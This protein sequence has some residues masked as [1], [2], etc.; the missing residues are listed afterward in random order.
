MKNILTSSSVVAFRYS[1]GI[2]LSSDTS[3]N[4][5]SL[6]MNRGVEKHYVLSNNTVMIVRG[7]Y[8]C[9]QELKK[10]CDEEMEYD[11]SMGT[12]EWIRFV[13][14]VMY[15]KRTRV[16]PLNLSVIV[17]GYDE[18]SEKQEK[19]INSV[20][21]FGQGLI[22]GVIDNVG[23]FYTDDVLA[24]GIASHMALPYIRGHGSTSLDREGA[25]KLMK[26]TMQTLYYRDCMADNH[27]KIVGVE[28]DG[29]WEN[30]EMV[31][32]GN[33]EDGKYF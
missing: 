20:E 11:Q 25:I 5:G 8:S 4:Y 2:I 3:L 29:I 23:N 22:F 28:K 30:E 33:W 12:K 17:A 27:I 7:E 1:N 24:C 26:E 18:H 13:Q 32:N 21:H 6:K 9:F 14:R 15:Y 31:L 19:Q 16:M 10:I